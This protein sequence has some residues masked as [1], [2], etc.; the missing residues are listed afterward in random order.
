MDTGAELHLQN[1]STALSKLRKRMPV[2]EADWAL[3]ECLKSY[4]NRE[5][6]KNTRFAVAGAW[7]SGKSTLVNALLGLKGAETQA[8]AL[9]ET[10]SIPTVVRPA[11][12]TRLLRWE[13]WELQEADEYFVNAFLELTPEIKALNPLL[14]HY[15]GM[16]WEVV[17]EIC[18][19]ECERG[20]EYLDLPGFLSGESGSKKMLNSMKWG[21]RAS[22]GLIY[23]VHGEQ[24][25]SREDVSFIKNF[26]PGD[27]PVLLALSHLDGA[28]K[29][30]ADRRAVQEK[31]E[32][33]TGK[34]LGARRIGVMVPGFDHSTNTMTLDETALQ[35]FEKLKRSNLTSITI[36]RDRLLVEMVEMICDIAK[37]TKTEEGCLLAISSLLHD[38]W[39]ETSGTKT[40]NGIQTPRGN[41][42][43][44]LLS[45]IEEDLLELSV[46]WEEP[47]PLLRFRLSHEWLMHKKSGL[48]DGKYATT[49]SEDKAKEWDRG[50]ANGLVFCDYL[51]VLRALHAK[52]TGGIWESEV[53][54]SGLLDDKNAGLLR[55]LRKAAEAGHLLS[56]RLLGFGLWP[57]EEI[58]F[59]KVESTKPTPFGLQVTF[60]Y[61]LGEC[62][63]WLWKCVL[64]DDPFAANKMLTRY[65]WNKK[66]P[67][68]Y[69]GAMDKYMRACIKVLVKCQA[70]GSSASAKFLVGILTSPT[71]F[72]LKDIVDVFEVIKEQDVGYTDTRDINSLQLYFIKRVK[73]LS[74]SKG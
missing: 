53:Q 50:A 39:D 58:F 59:T 29:T 52:N 38:R 35:I 13:G 17:R 24:G 48:D 23:M 1:I 19:P 28:G 6:A 54:L 26:V 72:M 15:L 37:Q 4:T 8:T 44:E 18:R 63:F 40:K 7:S 57:V 41:E 64:R 71:T 14:G 49:Q 74:I 55:R 34:L 9:A 66:S 69:I 31:L 47:P 12:S 73:E 22:D 68:V 61:V 67:L 3:V 21:I 32:K 11:E 5:S 45:H 46:H 42:I 33:D 56:Q 60:T 25:L 2:L 10:T 65:C 51:A 27:M 20:M 30:A 16:E 36:T 62:F 43:T 70:N